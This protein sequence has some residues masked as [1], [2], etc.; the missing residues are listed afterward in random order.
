L[1]SCHH[2]GVRRLFFYLLSL[3]SFS[4]SSLSPLSLLDLSASPP[5][6]STGTTRWAICFAWFRGVIPASAR[7]TSQQKVQLCAPYYHGHTCTSHHYNTLHFV[8][9]NSRTN[10]TMFTFRTEHGHDEE[11]HLVE[12]GQRLAA[13]L[14]CSDLARRRHAVA[15]AGRCVRLSESWTGRRR[16]TGMRRRAVF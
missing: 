13:G 9:Q 12:G 3:S 11:G 6:I 2:Y 1:T 8:E 4:H 16:R 7:V 5:C 14:G 15:Q 10:Q